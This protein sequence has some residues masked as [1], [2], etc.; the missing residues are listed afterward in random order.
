VNHST[1]TTSV[2]LITLAGSCSYPLLWGFSK[3]FLAV[4]FQSS[5]RGVF[6]GSWVGV[7]GV[8][9]L[10]PGFFLGLTESIYFA[11]YERLRHPYGF[12]LFTLA[13][14]AAYPISW[15]CCLITMP[16]RP[17][18]SGDSSIP[19]HSAFAAGFV[20]GLIILLAAM[21]F[22]AP[23]K[24]RWA[25]V[26]RVIFFAIDCGLLAAV[27]L[28]IGD[29]FKSFPSEDMGVLPLHLFWPAGAAFFLGLMLRVERFVRKVPDSLS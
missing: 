27:I 25:A 17:A 13:C 10:S 22:L 5:G 11:L 3:L 16:S 29:N 19:L 24:M 28:K 4:P 14:T 15:F 2:L 1:R 7:L 26:G 18:F 6:D 21:I 9:V 20:G 12:I 8:I 23:G